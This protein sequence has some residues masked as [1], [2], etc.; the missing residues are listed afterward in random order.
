MTERYYKNTPN[1]IIVNDETV[2]VL[3]KYNALNF[4]KSIDGYKPT[5]L[6]QLPNLSEK[7]QVGNIYVKDESHRFG[8]NAFKVLGASYAIN[9]SLEKDHSIVTFCTATD[10]NHGRAVAWSATRSGKRQLFLC[11]STPQQ[12]A[13]KPLKNT[14]LK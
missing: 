6:V 5:P 9:Q 7:Y 8:L 13:L 3:K 11:L 14:V 4:H 2:G 1:N 10:G 12:N